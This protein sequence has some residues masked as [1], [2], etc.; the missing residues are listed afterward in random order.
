L[1]TKIGFLLLLLAFFPA[2]MLLIVSL[3]AGIVELRLARC[4]HDYYEIEVIKL[5]Q[6]EDN[7]V[8]SSEFMACVKFWQETK[9]GIVLYGLHVRFG[10]FLTL[11]GLIA[12]N[13]FSLLIKH[14]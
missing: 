11:V 2:L 6:K 12:S 10:V 9:L 1:V 13:A 3:L 7:L 4:V 14:L 5:I 8:I